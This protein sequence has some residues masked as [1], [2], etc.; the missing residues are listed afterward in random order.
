MG[1]SDEET[2]VLICPPSR[3]SAKPEATTAYCQQCSTILYLAPSSQRFLV[4]A[5]ATPTVCIACAAQLLEHTTGPAR[6]ELVPGQEADLRDELGP[7]GVGLADQIVA[8]L[9]ARTPPRAAQR[10]AAAARRNG[11]ADG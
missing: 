3:T 10:W 5:P 7:A 9:N 1:D 8:E 6:V 4:A 2:T 11:A